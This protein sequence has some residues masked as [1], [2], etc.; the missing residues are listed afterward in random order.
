MNKCSV[1]AKKFTLKQKFFSNF[2]N[3]NIIV[4]H[5]CKTKYK[6]K[7]FSRI[8]LSICSVLIPGLVTTKIYSYYSL[9]LVST[10]VVFLVLV[11][12]GMSIGSIFTRYKT[13]K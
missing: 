3:K 1:C 11:A 8:L 5:N 7:I 13:L 6:I 4:C 10:A 12:I 2:T 9:N